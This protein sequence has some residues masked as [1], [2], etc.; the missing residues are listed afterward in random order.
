MAVPHTYT[1]RVGVSDDLDKND[2]LMTPNDVTAWRHQI[3]K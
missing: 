2:D 3:L 1:P